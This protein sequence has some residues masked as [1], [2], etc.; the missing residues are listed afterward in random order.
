MLTGKTSSLCYQTFARACCHV[1]GAEAAA[2]IDVE[3][4]IV[5]PGTGGERRGRGLSEP[6]SVGWSSTPKP[7][8]KTRPTLCE[9]GQGGIR[10][11]TECAP[12][13]FN[14]TPVSSERGIGSIVA[15]PFPWCLTRDTVHL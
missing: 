1:E 4:R 11:H 3:P 14:T 12:G 15:I 9:L 2:G 13:G 6:Q 10:T 5:V 7:V 8:T